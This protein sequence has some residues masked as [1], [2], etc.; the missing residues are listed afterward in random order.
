M[1]PNRRG[2]HTFL[3]NPWHSMGQTMPDAAELR[4]NETATR[5][6]AGLLNLLS[7]TTIFLLLFKPELDPVIYVGPFVIFDMFSAA[8][9]GLTPFTPTGVAGTL[10]TM[11]SGQHGGRRG[12]SA[13]PGSWAAHWASSASGCGSSTWTTFGSS[14]F[15]RSAS[16]SPGSR[17]C[18]A[19]ASAAGCTRSSSIARSARCPTAPDRATVKRVAERSLGSPSCANVLRRRSS[20]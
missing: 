14:V 8:I 6:R 7:I 17:R 20:G 5:A 10:A 9:F 4:L 15:S 19:S 13:S 12:R 16:S 2:Y 1:A 3:N 11:W 18:S